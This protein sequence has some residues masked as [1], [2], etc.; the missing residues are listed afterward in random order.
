MMVGQKVELIAAAAAA[1]FAPVS[2]GGTFAVE[3]EILFEL[4]GWAIGEFHF[5]VVEVLTLIT[6]HAG[7]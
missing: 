2:T 1:V 7:A 3:H 5:G 6:L 4:F